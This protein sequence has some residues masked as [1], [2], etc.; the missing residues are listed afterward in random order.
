MLQDACLL[1]VTDMRLYRMH[2]AIS[3]FPSRAF[4]KACIVDDSSVLCAPFP[5]RPPDVALPCGSRVPVVP[6]AFI[7]AALG[8]ETRGASSFANTAE[9]DVVECL[10]QHLLSACGMN[11]ARLGVITFY[12]AQ[13]T[14]LWTRLREHGITINTVDGFQGREMDVIIVSCTRTTRVGF[15]NDPRRLNVALTR[16][17]KALYIVGHA[18]TLNADG[19][20]RALIEDAD[21]RQV[22]FR[23]RGSGHD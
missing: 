11:P 23:L 3:H 5:G 14:E 19:N 6:Y 4:Y 1:F 15:L 9:V 20:W 10:V 18:P 13:R 8:S 7:D 21:R 17:R 2:P 16:A 12:K 22:L